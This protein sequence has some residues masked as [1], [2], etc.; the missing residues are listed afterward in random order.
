MLKYGK[1]GSEMKE[2]LQKLGLNEDAT[3]ADAIAEVEKLK[4]QNSKL[5]SKVK[6]LTVSE[7]GLK[8]D[9]EKTKEAY[10][11]LVEE[12]KEKEKEQ[13]KSIFDELTEKSE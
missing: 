1:G 7:T 10:E 9:L 6:E 3:E 11:S 8:A 2:L 12:G 5:D 4:N 13:P